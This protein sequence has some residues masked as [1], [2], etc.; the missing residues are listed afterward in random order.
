[1]P[2]DDAESLHAEVLKFQRTYF[3]KD[4]ERVARKREKVLQE[5]AEIGMF[6][7]LRLDM[8]ASVEIRTEQV[9]REMEGLAAN[10]QVQIPSLPRKLRK[11]QR[12]L[13]EIAAFCGRLMKDYHELDRRVKEN[14]EKELQRRKKSSS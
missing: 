14:I 9:M 2:P 7:Q 12:E 6:S 8:N 11:T 1:M 3:E 4:F 13:K 10:L 5:L